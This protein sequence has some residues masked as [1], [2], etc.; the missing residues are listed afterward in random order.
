MAKIPPNFSDVLALWTRSNRRRLIVSSHILASVLEDI[1][2]TTFV[3]WEALEQQDAR[4]IMCLHIASDPLRLGVSHRDSYSANLEKW[5]PK[6]LA[7]V[8]PL[9][10]PSLEGRE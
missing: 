2:A 4:Q 1:S 3:T 7:V 10:T 9:P 8:A 5:Y 6:R